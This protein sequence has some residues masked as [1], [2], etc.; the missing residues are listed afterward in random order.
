[1]LKITVS[2]LEYSWH[3][4]D[5]NNAVLSAESVFIKRCVCGGGWGGGGGSEDSY[6]AGPFLGTFAIRA[7]I[8]WVG[9]ISPHKVNNHNI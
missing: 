1:M 8:S 7:Q 6:E 5:H 4:W 3:G 2:S 9:S